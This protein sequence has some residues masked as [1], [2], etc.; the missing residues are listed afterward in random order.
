[1]EFIKPSL[2]LYVA[3]IEKGES[4][5]VFDQAI[6]VASRDADKIKPVVG[7]ATALT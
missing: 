6:A 2:G 7:E 5:C 4:G 1:M 3:E